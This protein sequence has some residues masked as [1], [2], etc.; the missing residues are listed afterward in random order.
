MAANQPMLIQKSMIEDRPEEGLLP[1]GQVAA[2][3][4]SQDTCEAIVNA[5]VQEAEACLRAST[6]YVSEPVS[7]AA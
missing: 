4:R 7:H 2:A 1:S 5:L 3:I 6:H